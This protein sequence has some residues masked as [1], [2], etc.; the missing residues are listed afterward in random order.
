MQE[1]KKKLPL[2]CKRFCNFL[3]QVSFHAL[4]ELL[5]AHLHNLD[6]KQQ[7]TCHRLVHVSMKAQEPSNKFSHYRK[8]GAGSEAHSYTINPYSSSQEWNHNALQIFLTCCLLHSAWAAARSFSTSSGTAIK[9]AMEDYCADTLHFL[10]Q[11]VSLLG[12][13]LPQASS[14]LSPRWKLHA[15]DYT[16][17]YKPLEE[18]DL[19]IPKLRVTPRGHQ[20]GKKKIN[21]SGA[22]S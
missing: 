7:N 10:F 14:M 1:N 12:L 19:T 5:N 21:K 20:R 22:H 11:Y 4:S 17:D 8:N 9:I 6:I 2:T 3:L 16:K 15:E 18:I 13:V